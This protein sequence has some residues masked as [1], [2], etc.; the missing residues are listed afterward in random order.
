MKHALSS[1]EPTVRFVIISLHSMLNTHEDCIQKYKVDLEKLEKTTKDK[2][3]K[4]KVH[5]IILVL[6]G[7]TYVYKV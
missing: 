6:E 5:E 3:V 1:R 4:E 7:K 2:Q